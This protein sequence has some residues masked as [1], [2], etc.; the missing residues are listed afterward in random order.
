MEPT[1]WRDGARAVRELDARLPPAAYVRLPERTTVPQPDLPTLGTHVL[2]YLTVPW[3]YLPVSLVVALLIIAGF[4][5]MRFTSG[6]PALIIL[7][8]AMTIGGHRWV[9]RE[10]RRRQRQ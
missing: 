6:Q 4:V 7:L 9:V 3:I 10:Y 5:A 1:F 8:I 2:G